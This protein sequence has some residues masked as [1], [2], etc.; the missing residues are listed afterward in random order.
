MKN[1]YQ[2]GENITGISMKIPLRE[3]FLMIKKV[4]PKL[5][6]LGIFYCAEM[7]QT[8]A[9]GRKAIALAPQFGWTPLPVFISKSELSQLKKVLKT[10]TSKVGAVY[11]STDPILLEPEN[12]KRIIR[13]C[14]ESQTPVITATKES[15]KAGAL[16]A[17]HCDFSEIG[18]QI[19]HIASQ[20]LKGVDISRIP[21]TEPTI[22]ILSLN[23][24][25][26]QQLNIQ[27]D[28]NV[29]LQAENI[30]D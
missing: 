17:L 23:L 10:L 22:T 2:S 18:R 5:Q 20:V 9:L 19:A 15:V 21:I 1:Y 7:P 24:K 12:L 25:K 13:V 14:D 8:V 27:I 3:Q 16:M 6:K 29:I 26:A 30:F 28:H 4:L 11:I